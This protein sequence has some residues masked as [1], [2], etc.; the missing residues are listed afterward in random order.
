I[1]KIAPPPLPTPGKGVS[2]GTTSKG[3]ARSRLR[4]S[5]A[6]EG[7]RDHLRDPLV[8]ERWA[9]EVR[10][11]RPRS[12]EGRAGACAQAGRDQPRHLS[13]SAEAGN[14][15]PVR[16]GVVRHSQVE[17][18]AEL[19]RGLQDHARMSP[20]PRSRRVLP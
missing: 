13:G 11:D 10:N 4:S 2:N 14:A 16:F 3:R 17:A 8:R 9:A 15:P 7:A 12:K 1:L 20:A 19:S 5:E 18:Q 6:V